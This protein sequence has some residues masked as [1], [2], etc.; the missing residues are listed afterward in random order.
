MPYNN[1]LFKRYLQSTTGA[2]QVPRPPAPQPSPQA[3]PPK[4]PISVA[5]VEHETDERGKPVYNFS[6]SKETGDLGEKIVAKFMSNGLMDTER[7]KFMS[8]QRVTDDAYWRER[9]VD[10]IATFQTAKGDVIRQK[11][12]IKTDT[13]TTENLFYEY[14]SNVDEF[15]ASGG[16]FGVGCLD[17]TE[18][19]ILVYYLI[20][21]DIMYVFHMGKLR[22][23]MHKNKDQPWVRTSYVRN[24][25]KNNQPE[26]KTAGYVFNRQYLH[27]GLTYEK[28]YRKYD[29]IYQ[30]AR[31]A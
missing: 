9:D 21:L 27:D 16:K 12:E 31:P 20:N 15:N 25:P 26:Y 18:A 22:E 7:L 28:E 11:I 30:R 5:K 6:N 4:Q 24:K 23:W 8:I 29:N 17:K 2:R 14:I 19:N 3:R 13:Y 1:N 10:F